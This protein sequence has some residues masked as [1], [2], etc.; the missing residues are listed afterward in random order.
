MWNASIFGLFEKERQKPAL[1]LLKQIEDGSFGRILDVGCGT[2]KSTVPLLEKYPNAEIIGID[3]SK[4][5]LEAARK[6]TDKVTWIC[7]DGSQSLMDLGKFDLVFSNA[8]MPWIADQEVFI[9]NSRFI[10]NKGG[11]F[12]AQLP[13]FESLKITELILEAVNEMDPDGHIFAGVQEK[14]SYTTN[15]QEYYD[16]TSRYFPEL[17]IWE[18]IYYYQMNDSSEIVDFMR[19]AYL[20]PYLELLDENQKEAFLK[21]IYRK[22][23]DHYQDSENGMVLFKFKR[24]FILARK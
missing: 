16:V 4:H 2:G 11:V 19:G 10:L 15:V 6:I 9:R 22:A 12:A 1:D 18:T 7:R 5:M 20:L 8:F 23:E 14:T 17:D 21:L 3:L 24:I 13:D